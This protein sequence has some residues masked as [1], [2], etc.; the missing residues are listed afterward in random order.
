M[1]HFIWILSP[2]KTSYLLRLRVRKSTKTKMI[3][4]LPG[5]QGSA[6]HGNNNKWTSQRKL[7]FIWK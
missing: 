6:N 4:H 7:L 3:Q 5:I 1:L 2:N